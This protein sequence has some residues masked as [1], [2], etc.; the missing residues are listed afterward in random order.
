MLKRGRYDRYYGYQII[1]IP[2]T[3]FKEASDSM[4]ALAVVY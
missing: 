3:V 1:N 2:D 4:A